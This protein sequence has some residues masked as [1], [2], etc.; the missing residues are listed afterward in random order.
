MNQ[1]TRKTAVAGMVAVLVL[2]VGMLGLADNG[3]FGNPFVTNVGSNSS[4][5][6]SNGGSAQG[7]TD[8]PPFPGF[9]ESDAAQAESG[10]E[11]ALD[12][13]IQPMVGPTLSPSGSLGTSLFS[14]FPITISG[15]NPP[16]AKVMI[17]EWTVWTGWVMTDLTSYYPY[18]STTVLFFAD[19]YGPHVICAWVDG[20]LNLSVDPGEVTPYL[21]IWVQ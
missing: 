16:Y 19:S 12:M 13:I 2:A 17:A 7:P 3:F 8:L 15:I 4:G 20:N 1:V 9:D 21:F 5:G 11:E 6:S 14:S 18:G 10:G